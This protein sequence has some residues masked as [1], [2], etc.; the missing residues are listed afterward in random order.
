MGNISAV[1]D[2]EFEAQVL[3]SDK[4]V[5][6]DFWAEWCGPC[7]QVAPILE[8]IAAEHGEKVT[9]VKMNVDEN[10]VTPSSYRVT[11]I[12]TL[13]LYQGGEVV[14]SIVGARPK[15]ALLNELSDVIV[16]DSSTRARVG[17]PVDAR[18]RPSRLTGGCALRRGVASGAR[19]GFGAGRTT[20]T[21]RSSAASTSLFQVT[22][23][24]RSIRIRGVAGCARWVRKP[25]PL[26]KSAGTVHRRWARPSRPKASTAR[27]SRSTRSRAI[28]RTSIRPTP[29]PRAAGSTWTRRQQHRIGG[30]RGGR[31]AG[32]PRHEPG[33]GVD[34]VADQLVVDERDPPA[35]APLAQHLGDPRLLL[36]RRLV[37]SLPAYGIALPEQAG[38]AGRGDRVQVV[39]GQPDRRSAHDTDH[40]T[41]APTCENVAGAPDPAEQEAPPRPLRRAWTDPG[42]G[43]AARGRGPPDPQAQHRQPGAVRLRGARGDRRRRRP[44]PARRAGLQRLP[45]HL[46][47]PD[48]GRAVLPAARPARRQRRRRL[49]R[50]RRLRADLDGAAGLHRRRQRGAGARRR[51]TRC[52]PARSRCRAVRRST[53]S[54]TRRTTGTPTWPTSSPRSPRTRT[55]WSSSTP[56]TPPV[57]STAGRRS[58]ASSTS[59]D[60]TSWSSSPTRSTRRS[61]ST[62]P[63]TTTRRPRPATT[64]SA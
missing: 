22:A 58:R 2:A 54:A 35:R 41:R 25:T 61:S 48:R 47:R 33:R 34:H 55:R 3:K 56:T 64:C 4:P 14:K 20:P 16:A 11:G 21:S 40:L 50:Q 23:A 31:E 43:P 13:N 9:I 51:T 7:R 42:R 10:P 19:R 8:E 45:G 46:P 52:G 53:T 17:R 29:P 18:D 15:A 27:M 6:V 12:P 59:P 38:P 5:L 60:V 39:Q 49:H 28:A 24:R 26:R 62:T 44:P 57:P 30:D 36:G 37:E 32:R 1:T 63:S